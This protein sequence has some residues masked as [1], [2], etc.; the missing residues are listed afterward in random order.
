MLARLRPWLAAP[1]RRR[2]AELAR[3]LLPWVPDSAC[4]LDIGSGAGLL[5]EQLIVAGRDVTLLDVVDISMVPGKRATLFDGGRI[6]F[7]DGAFDVAL[8]ITVLH[9]VRDPDASLAEA[10]RVAQQVI[11]L[12]DLVETP[13]ERFWT[14]LG[15]SWL[16]WEWRGHPHSNRS[17][18]GWRAAYAKLGMKVIHAEQRLHSFWPWR[19]RHGLYVLAS[20]TT[21]Q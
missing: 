13:R 1:N 19:F 20:A 18:A 21:A 10:A 11:V 14:Q 4:V 15:D 17:D 3:T 5:A 12:E 6:P 8:L 16:N 2:A 9:H 7:E